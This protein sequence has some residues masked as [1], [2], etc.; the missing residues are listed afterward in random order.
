MS[1]PKPH[2][3]RRAGDA[4]TRLAA[5]APA[6]LLAILALIV[7]VG[8]AYD[9]WRAAG[10]RREARAAWELTLP[11]LAARLRQARPLNLGGVWATHAGVI[12]GTVEGRHSF[13]G[14]VG[15][16]PFYAVAGRPAVFQ[17][18]STFESFT[19]VWRDCLGDHW[20]ALHGGSQKAGWCATDVGRRRCRANDYFG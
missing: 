12:C 11:A 15:M 18:E 5:A 1:V 20:I 19:P 2:R 4:S 6:L 10:A 3:R 14:T 17:A 9:H 16:T 8:S 13:T 7:G